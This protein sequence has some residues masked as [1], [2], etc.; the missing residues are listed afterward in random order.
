MHH[1]G[2][3]E[4]N[5]KVDGDNLALPM[6][7]FLHPFDLSD[8]SIWKGAL[9]K[10][11][12]RRGRSKNL[13]ADWKK[14]CCMSHLLVKKWPNHTSAQVTARGSYWYEVRHLIL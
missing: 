1:Q 14:N 12:E 6:E 11:L 2:P 7:R 5:R 10:Y 8:I 4:G 13:K 9:E 3:A